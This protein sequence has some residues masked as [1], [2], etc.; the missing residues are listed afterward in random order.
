MENVDIT[1]ALREAVKSGDVQ[2][3][4]SIIGDSPDRLHQMTPFG[5]WL[6]IAAK[7]GK[8][9]VL[10]ALIGMGADINAKGGTL[11]GAA[12][13]LAANGGHLKVVQALV[14]AGAEFDVSEPERNPL[15]GAITGG[16]IE[17]VKFLINC[18][19]DHSVRYTGRS[20]KNMDAEAFA[21]E[22]GQTAIA[23]FLLELKAEPEPKE[24]SSSS[25]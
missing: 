8:F 3:V 2:Q 11:G 13:N 15:F 1:K 18:K 24:I 6:H 21:R 10:Q 17:V 19:I 22:R 23:D 14:E 20:M 25:C 12:I 7:S 16:H 5:T 4:C 9:E